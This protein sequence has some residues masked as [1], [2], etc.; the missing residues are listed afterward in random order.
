MKMGN[1]KTKV[2]FNLQWGFQHKKIMLL[3]ISWA[4]G[5]QQKGMNAIN[6]E[7]SIVNIQGPSIKDV[8]K[9]MAIFDPLPLVLFK[10]Y[11]FLSFSRVLT[12]IS[13]LT[14]LKETCLPSLHIYC[15]QRYIPQKCS[16][17][18]AMTKSP[19]QLCRNQGSKVNKSDPT[20]PPSYG[21]PLWMTRLP[22]GDIDVLLIN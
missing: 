16:A 12:R 18:K 10:L 15:N 8:R 1:I 2:K 21:R 11:Y 4:T 3:F 14:T 13:L 22:L 20:S 19:Q 9:I 17:S 5:M 6:L 7:T